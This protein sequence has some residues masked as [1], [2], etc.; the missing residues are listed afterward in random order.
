MAPGETRLSC[1][2]GGP[3][4]AV[5]AMG[6]SED[7]A[8]AISRRSGKAKLSES[9]QPRSSACITLVSEQAL[10]GSLMKLG[11]LEQYCTAA[12]ESF[13]PETRKNRIR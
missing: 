6:C 7:S 10:I 3:G 2:S 1:I 13:I 5:E 9:Y 12:G 4:D 11:Y 8:T